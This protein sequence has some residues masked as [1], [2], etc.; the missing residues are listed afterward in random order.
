VI[1]FAGHLV[2]G[3]AYIAT[4]ILV[5]TLVLCWTLTH[6]NLDRSLMHR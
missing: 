1:K 6:D 4:L 2:V 5:L 3:V